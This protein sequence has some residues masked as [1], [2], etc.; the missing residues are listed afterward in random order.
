MKFEGEH[1]FLG[2]LGHFFVLLT[3]VTALLA[4]VAFFLGSSQKLDATQ[5]QNWLKLARISFFIQFIGI[6]SIFSIVFYICKNHYYEYMYVYK[7]ASLELEAKYLLACIWEGQEGSFLLWSMWHGLLG[8]LIILKNKFR[9]ADVFEAP[10]MTVISLAQFFLMMMILGIYIGD[11]RLGNS[12]FT[13]TR[14]EIVAPIFSQPNYLDFI[15]DGMGLNVLLRNYWMVIHPPVLFLGFASTLIPFGYAYAGL[16]LKRYGEW[17]KP[18]IPFTL[19]AACVL[20]VGIMMGGKWAYESLSF[21]GY[22]A[23]D[24]VEKCIL[25][26]LVTTNFRLTYFSNL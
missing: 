14:N 26:S 6:I 23:W 4:T 9:K 10:V 20:G 8:C 24:P 12:L 19:L 1:L 15:K 22:W 3:F 16:K 11:T 21:G 2:Q 17:V 5:K 7:H 25:S 18:A 13:L